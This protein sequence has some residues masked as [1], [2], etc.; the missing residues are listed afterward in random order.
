MGSLRQDEKGM[1]LLLALTMITVMVPIALA[2]NRSTR[3]TAVQTALTRD[4]ISLN[5][6]AM[7]GLNLGRAL[8]IRD[9]LDTD[10]DSLHETWA[11][12]EY[13]HALLKAPT[14]TACMKPGPTRNTSMLF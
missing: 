2:V 9:R 11:D 4:D 13:I 5:H 3:N 6:M 10:I 7:S 14:S 1:A 12:P 8:L